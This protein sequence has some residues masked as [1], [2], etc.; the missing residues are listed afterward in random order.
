MAAGGLDAAR[1]TTPMSPRRQHMFCAGVAAFAD[2]VGREM[3]V[4]ALGCE[5]APGARG[6]TGALH[7]RRA[8]MS[9]A[10]DCERVPVAG[11]D[12]NDPF[13]SILCWQW[14]VVQS[15]FTS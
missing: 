7:A 11:G 1:E 6:A 3:M 8:G 5:R 14:Y 2:D 13:R 9:T 4:I 15:S 12:A 10:P